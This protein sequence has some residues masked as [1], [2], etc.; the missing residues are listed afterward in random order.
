MPMCLLAYSNLSLSPAPGAWFLSLS[1]SC[2]RCVSDALSYK[3]D[4]Q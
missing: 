2:A 3:A 4:L 1:V